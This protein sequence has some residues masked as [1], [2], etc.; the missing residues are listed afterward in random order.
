MTSNRLSLKLIIGIALAAFFAF[1]LLTRIALPYER[2]FRDGWIN[3]TSVDAYWQMRHIDN[4]VRNFPHYSPFDPYVPFPTAGPQR[5]SYSFF[6][7]LLAII[8]WIAGAGAPTQH[9]ADLIGVY[10]P[11]VLGA[12]TVF[13]VY[14]LGK[15]LFNRW[16]GLLAAGLLAI[17]PGEFLNRSILGFTDQHVAE[18]LFST[19]AMLFFVLALNEGREKGLDFT[20]LRARDGKAVIKPLVYSVLAGVF[21]AI[22]LL[23]WSGA[24]LFIFLLVCFLIVQFLIHH[25]RHEPSAYLGLTGFVTLLAAAVIYLPYSLAFFRTV[26]VLVALLVPPVLWAISALLRQRNFPVYY[27][28]L[29]LLGLGTAGLVIFHLVEPEMLRSMLGYFSV[30]NPLGDPGTTTT[31]MERVLFPKGEFSFS[32]VWSYFTA[33]FFLSLG[34]LGILVYLLVKSRDNAARNLCLVWTVII[35][36]AMLGQ[37][38]FAYYFA[39]N[40]A[41]LTGYFSWLFLKLIMLLTDWLA[42]RMEAADLKRTAVSLLSV[43]SP[44]PSAAESGQQAATSPLKLVMVSLSVI[45]LFLFVYLPNL[46]QVM[47]IGLGAYYAPSDAWLSTVLWLKENTPDPFGDPDSYYGIHPEVREGEIYVYPETAY[48][49]MTWWDYGYL[50][51]RVAHRLPSCDPSQ[52][53]Q[54]II[55]TANFFLSPSEEAARENTWGQQFPYIVLDYRTTTNIFPA[56]PTRAGEDPTQYLEEY[57]LEYEGDLVATY[58]F[59]PEYYRCLCVR[60]YNFDGKAVIPQVTLTITYEEENRSGETIKRITDFETFDSYQ[61]ALDFILKEPD[62]NWQIMGSSP[63]LCPIPLEALHDYRLVFAS[64][65]SLQHHDAGNIPEVKVFEHAVP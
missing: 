60:L 38:R 62:K 51:S 13:P 1:A 2:V 4:L 63:F 54:P 29:A 3:F 41:V 44:E 43:P 32:T 33:G 18:V 28:P 47:L 48:G 36:M 50:I 5:I 10:Y 21:L 58:L 11:A 53:E 65:E 55:N 34:A 19:T 15:A 59:Y 61:K 42:G 40:V 49:V 23:T 26:S 39:V 25:L 6:Q 64:G 9:L 27:Y 17:L 31:E 16:A 12:L 46:P 7:W 37:R 30:L 52:D 24:L 45:V 57:Y 14:F 8:I 20:R 35:L 56:I 22:Y